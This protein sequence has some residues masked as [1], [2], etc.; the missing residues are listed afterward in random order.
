MKRGPAILAALL[1]SGCGAAET[2]TVHDARQAML[3]RNVVDVMACA[4][5]PDRPA[6][7][8]APD[9]LLLQYDYKATAS[10]GSSSFSVTLPFGFGAK[11]G[12]ASSECHMH[13]RVLRD[14]TVAGVSFSGPAL[15]DVN[16]VCS[17]MVS[18]CVIHP[19]QTALPAGYDAIK[20]LLPSKGK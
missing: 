3:G 13:L 15:A 12:A 20:T 19:D 8:T 9:E 1:L 6:L 10:V 5:I 11:L 7:Q 14:G 2:I 4:G 18:E 17:G 16:G